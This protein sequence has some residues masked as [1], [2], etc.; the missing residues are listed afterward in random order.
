MWR[1]RRNRAGG[2]PPLTHCH[3]HPPPAYQ[4]LADPRDGV[5]PMS[6]DRLPAH[7]AAPPA[8]PQQFGSVS[9]A[10]GSRWAAPQEAAPSLRDAPQHRQLQRPGQQQERRVNSPGSASLASALLG[11]D[12]HSATPFTHGAAAAASAA[13]AAA[14]AR[15]QAIGLQQPPQPSWSG[16]V[17]RSSNSGGGTTVGAAPFHAG[18]AH[19][20]PPARCAL[21]PQAFGSRRDCQEQEESLIG[22]RQALSCIAPVPNAKPVT[23][24]LK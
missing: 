7:Q 9:S 3:M 16:E 20:Y 11:E 12:T 1:S 14:L 10:P 17:A 15:P 19:D 22:Q 13:A 6:I 21:R 5:A 18:D 24:P 2:A 4:Q 23:L 8:P